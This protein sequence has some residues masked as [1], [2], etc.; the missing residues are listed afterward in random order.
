[1]E[2]ESLEVGSMLSIL[3][4]VARCYW[5]IG[6]ELCSLPECLRLI[7]FYPDKKIL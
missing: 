2:D 7:V 6:V 5:T 3:L 4:R 1:M